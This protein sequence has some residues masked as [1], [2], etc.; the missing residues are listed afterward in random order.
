MLIV[1]VWVNNIVQEV[2]LGII[3]ALVIAV[4]EVAKSLG[5]PTRWCPVL[6]VLL[7]VG[8]VLG[9]TFFQPATVVVFTGIVIGLSAVGLYSGARATV[10]K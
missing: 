7:G 10:G 3:T 8:A 2:S 5:L 6:A 4:V 9:L 1:I